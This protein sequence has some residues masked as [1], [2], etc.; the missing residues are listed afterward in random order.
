MAT[1]TKAVKDYVAS[2]LEKSDLETV[3]CI[4]ITIEEELA[5][6]REDDHETPAF[7]TI[8]VLLLVSLWN[9]VS[10]YVILDLLVDKLG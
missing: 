7:A 9:G 2:E 8:F 6:H 3:Q 10:A 1:V 5:H 4:D